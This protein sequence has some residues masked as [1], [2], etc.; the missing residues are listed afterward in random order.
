MLVNMICSLPNAMLETKENS[1]IDRDLM[2]RLPP[3]SASCCLRRSAAQYPEIIVGRDKISH[4]RE[5]AECGIVFVELCTLCM[6][7]SSISTTHLS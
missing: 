1:E 7:T 6:Y 2:I 4:F 5:I 3:S